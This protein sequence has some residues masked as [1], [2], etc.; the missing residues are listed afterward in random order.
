MKHL[1]LEYC[2][3]QANTTLWLRCTTNYWDKP[4]MLSLQ[5]KNIPF[6]KL[7]Y[8]KRIRSKA[9]WNKY[10]IFVGH[11]STFPRTP[12]IV[13]ETQTFH[14]CFIPTRCLFLIVPLHQNLVFHVFLSVVQSSISPLGSNYIPPFITVF[15]CSFLYLKKKNISLIMNSRY[16]ELFVMVVVLS[17]MLIIFIS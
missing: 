11:K 13:T 2:S 8:H 5:Q 15:H 12:N 14:F 7:E 1:S 16:S 6:Q 17:I 4:E 9:L 10:L 3:S